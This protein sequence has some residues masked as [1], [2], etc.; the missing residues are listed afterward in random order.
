MKKVLSLVAVGFFGLVLAQAAEKQA[1]K[2]QTAC[3]V[4]GEELGEHGEPS[5]IHYKGRT[6]KFCCPACEKPFK[7]EP[8]KYLNSMPGEQAKQSSSKKR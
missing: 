6:V 8:D 5:V 7:A 3:P 2:P 1:G 4:S